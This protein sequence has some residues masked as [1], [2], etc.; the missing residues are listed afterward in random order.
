MQL[1][2]ITLISIWPTIPLGSRCKSRPTARL[3]RFNKTLQGV[4]DDGLAKKYSRV[5][6]FILHPKRPTFTKASEA[7]WQ[8]ICGKKLKFNPS[9]FTLQCQRRFRFAAS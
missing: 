8:T 7:K 1:A 4:I 2:E 3:Q 9:V 5:V 6:I